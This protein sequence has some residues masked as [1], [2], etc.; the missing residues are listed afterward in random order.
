MKY[1]CMDQNIDMANVYVGEH[2]YKT[3]KRILQFN[4]FFFVMT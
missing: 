3:S 2:L 1:I 4:T